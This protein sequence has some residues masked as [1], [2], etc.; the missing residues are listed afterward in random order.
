MSSTD[1]AVLARVAIGDVTAFGELYDRYAARVLGLVVKMLG[2]H[3]D[4]EDVLQDVFWQVW[5]CAAD[6]C[7]N[8]GSPAAWLFMIARS[9]ACDALRRHRANASDAEFSSLS[10]GTDP[11]EALAHDELCQAVLGALAELPDEQ[12]TAIQLAFYGGMTHNEIA[13]IQAAPLGTIKTRIRLGM[14]RLRE[15]LAAREK[16]SST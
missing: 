14:R 11:A 6:Y 13:T 1:E 7:P 2:Q 12:R 10:A 9:R 16:V 3:D 5:R 8:R 15:L 4:A